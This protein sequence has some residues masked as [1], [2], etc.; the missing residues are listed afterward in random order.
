MSEP[1][2]ATQ[3]KPSLNGTVNKINRRGRAKF[4][5]DDADEPFEVDV[6]AVYD[7]WCD[8]DMILRE[9]DETENTWVLP[10]NKSDEYGKNRLEFVQALVNDAYAKMNLPIPNLDRAQA[11]GFIAAIL[12][13]AKTLRNFT[14]QKKETPS[15]PPENSGTE[16]INFSQ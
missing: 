7:A 3:A 15:S 9:R 5:F 10:H 1:L 4:Q 8:V 2:T 16:R 11:E 14:S 12:E 13:V 6:L